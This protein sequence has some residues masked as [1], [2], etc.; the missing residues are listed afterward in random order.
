[1]VVNSEKRPCCPCGHDTEHAWVIEHACY[2]PFGWFLILIG[3]SSLP[4][5]V[6]TKCGKCG[7]VFSKTSDPDICSKKRYH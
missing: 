6:E 4:K 5:A 3:I 2:S 1:M 7:F